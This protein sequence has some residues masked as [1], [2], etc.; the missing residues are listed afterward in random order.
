MKGRNTSQDLKDKIIDEM[1]RKKDRAD[2]LDDEEK[3]H[4]N[5]RDKGVTRD[6]ESVVESKNQSRTCWKND[7]NDKS[8]W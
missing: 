4:Q 1:F 7:N 8:L 3:K 5:S 2:R 6:K